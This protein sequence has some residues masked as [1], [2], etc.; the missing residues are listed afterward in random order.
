VAILRPFARFLSDVGAPVEGGLQRIGLPH[1]VLERADN[2]IPSHR[3]YA[4]LVS[5]A[6]REGIEDLG[7][8]VGQ[9]YGADN[10]DPH[11]TE[12]LCQSPT[13]YDGLRRAIDL[14][15]ATVTQSRMGV[16]ELPDS[17]YTYFYHRPSCAASNPAIEQI[18]WFGV[19][20]LIGMVRVFAGPDWQPREIGLMRQNEARVSIREQ[21]ADTCLRLAQP[22]SYIAVERTLL[23][24]PPALRGGSAAGPISLRYEPAAGDF[25]GSLRQLLRSYLEAGD[26]SVDVAAELCGT[27]T[28]TL[29]RRLTQ[30]GTHYFE[31][32]D[33]ARFDVA[34]RMLQDPGVRVL[35][36]AHRLGYRHAPHFTRCFRRIA[37]VTPRAYRAAHSNAHLDQPME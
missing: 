26:L 9:R 7:F 30:R 19:L 13:L 1:A 8:R 10:V 23:S 29:Q 36:V 20:T 2:Y 37:G 17:A 16:F 21:L 6:Q 15:N 32:L 25:A 5:M 12:R 3:F 4:F 33:Q 27:S 24:L 14:A 35:D 31:V 28:R 11:L 18:G 34:S 22:F